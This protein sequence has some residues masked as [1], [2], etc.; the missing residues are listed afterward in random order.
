MN[1]NLAH[2][3]LTAAMVLVAATTA[4]LSAL[5]CVTLATGALDCSASV[6]PPTYSGA[7][8][9]G[10]GIIKIVINITRD[11]VSGLTKPQPPVQ[12]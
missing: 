4:G 1:S 10:L 6:L 5:G 3:L 12:K 8:I 11:G 7:I 9:A 2:N